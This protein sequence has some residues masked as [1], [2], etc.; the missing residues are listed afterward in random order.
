[1]KEIWGLVVVVND[2]DSFMGRV[3]DEC[4]VV[5]EILHLLR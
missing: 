4:K 1:M 2:V 5:D 3:A